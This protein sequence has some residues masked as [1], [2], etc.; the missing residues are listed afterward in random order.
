MQNVKCSVASSQFMEVHSSLWA[1]DH[2]E[3]CSHSYLKSIVICH[4]LSHSKIH[5]HANKIFGSYRNNRKQ[6]TKYLLLH[7]EGVLWNIK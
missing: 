5:I 2:M 6:G 3:Q 1:E 4:L 7:Y